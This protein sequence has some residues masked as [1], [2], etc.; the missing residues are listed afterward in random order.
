VDVRTSSANNFKFF[1]IY[2]VSAR[3]RGVESV[4]T[5]CGQGGKGKFNEILCGSLVR[6]ASFVAEMCLCS[7]ILCIIQHVMKSFI[8]DLNIFISEF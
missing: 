3:T 8:I 7:L 6:I 4:R 1:E 5:F 2:G